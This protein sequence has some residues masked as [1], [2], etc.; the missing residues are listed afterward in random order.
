MRIDL[1]SFVLGGVALYFGHRWLK[2]RKI[3]TQRKKV[4]PVGPGAVVVVEETVSTPVPAVEAVSGGGF[5]AGGGPSGRAPEWMSPYLSG[6][7]HSGRSFQ[8]PIVGPGW[9]Y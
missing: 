4:V 8:S 9:M 5:F 7:P 1:G 6:A 2:G 3:L